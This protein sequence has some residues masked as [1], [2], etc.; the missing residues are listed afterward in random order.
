MG[1][2][3]LNLDNARQ[4]KAFED[5]VNENITDKAADLKS[6]ILEQIKSMDPRSF[7][8]VEKKEDKSTLD[9]QKPVSPEEAKINTPEDLASEEVKISSDKPN[10]EPNIIPSGPK[11]SLASDPYALKIIRDVLKRIDVQQNYELATSEKRGLK[12][13]LTARYK[14]FQHGDRPQQI[15]SLQK[16]LIKAQEDIDALIKLYARAQVNPDEAKNAMA[17]IFDGLES[18][19]QDIE[20]QMEAA[21]HK[22]KG[23][24]RM[25]NVIKDLRDQFDELQ[26][27]LGLEVKKPVPKSPIEESTKKRSAK[28]E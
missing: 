20:K 22:K 14:V 8:K 15:V 24:S 1:L 18:T 11:T 17:R 26:T 7:K 13:T 16:T 25:E 4:F 28:K 6:V 10:T 12:G 2:D 19:M 21:G 27:G 3:N 5:F 23:T 9:T